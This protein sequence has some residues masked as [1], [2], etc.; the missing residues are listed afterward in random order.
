MGKIT[1]VDK[2]REENKQLKDRW[3]KLKRLLMSMNSEVNWQSELWFSK[4][5]LEKMFDSEKGE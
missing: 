5:V 4:R 3:T 2:L 1:N